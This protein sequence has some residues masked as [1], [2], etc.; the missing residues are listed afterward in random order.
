MGGLFGSTILEVALS[1]FFIYFLL[2]LMCSHVNELIAGLFKSRAKDLEQGIEN[3]VCDPDIAQAVLKHPLIKALGNTDAETLPV[4]LLT[5]AETAIKSLAGKGHQDL[6][7]KLEYISAR[8]F[9][10]A[11]FDQLVPSENE[12]ITVDGLRQRAL[13]LAKGTEKELAA[14]VEKLTGSIDKALKS[15][16]QSAGQLN[17]LR[18]QIESSQTLDD[19]C[20]ILRP[21]PA[22]APLEAKGRFQTMKRSIGRESDEV[23]A[24]IEG[25]QSLG[26]ALLSLI[27]QSGASRQFSVT[28]A[29]ARAMITKLLDSAAASGSLP[30]EQQLAL[31][32]LREAVNSSQTLDELR[33][34][35]TL[36][37][38][39]GIRTS[40]LEFLDQGQSELAAVR[41]QVELWYDSAMEQVSGVYKRR[42]QVWL[43]VTAALISC[44]IGADSVRMAQ[45]LFRNT[46]LRQ[47]L[48]D[49]A[50]QVTTT[51]DGAFV[52][53]AASAGADGST[54]VTMVQERG[55]EGEE[56][57]LRM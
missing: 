56:E 45:T 20:A 54:T 50:G 27:D 57:N 43:F 21:P 44:G 23:L 47:S 39:S 32:L 46:D 34:S 51:P 35:I 7:G 13:E 3:L 10:A 17:V 6:A 55:R 31:R 19:L 42:T 53:P 8:T 26:R 9:A 30:S 29:E 49:R 5:R 22:D 16:P 4:R 1:L 48:A 41:K 40:A 37:P 12:P 28:V 2:S 33:K 14:A 36:L 38:A 24:T 15:T 52:L 11:I 25:K 18:Q